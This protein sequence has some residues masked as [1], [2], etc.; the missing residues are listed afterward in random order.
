MKEASHMND[1]CIHEDSIAHLKFTAE[2]KDE[3]GQHTAIHHVEKFNVWR[4]MDLL[5]ESIINDI[6]HKPVGQGDFHQ[7]NKNELIPEWTIKQLVNV[8]VKNFTGRIQGKVL[9]PKVG[10]YYPKGMVS[11]VNG[12]YSENMFP[13][14]I[15]EKTDE[16]IVVDYNH[17]LAS[18]SI[19]LKVDILDILPPTDE[20]G[21]RCADVVEEM[22]SNGPGMQLPCKQ[23]STDFFDKDA[24]RRVDESED[25]IFYQQSRKV[26]HLDANARRIISE[27]YGELIAPG[28][29]VLDLMASWESHLP[30]NI[31]N[32]KVSGLGMNQDEMTANPVLD[33]FLV[34]DL[35][36]N[37]ALPYSDESFDAVIC[38]ASVEYLTQ[39]ID[40]FSNIKSVLKPGG[41]FIV[42]FSNR[43]FPTKSI[44]LW[45]EMHDFER[46]GLVVEYFRQSSWVGEINTLTSRGLHRPVD[47][48]H[49]SKT[50]VSD[51]VYVVWS[52]K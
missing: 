35:N 31:A 34:H 6:I 8:P 45:S 27:I 50:Q 25:G 10:R 30:E 3:T 12:I 17:P 1:I 51:P 49:Y 33:N 2:W 39:P 44:Q 9:E 5:P 4:D 41:I 32:V 43:W 15:V 24:F 28:S 16:E 14:R 38:T 37:H 36:E 52:R 48:P 23:K 47:D 20:H 7:F 29:N 11:G 13:T 26:H 21:G 40:V 19:N 18:K 46:I 42:A 22:L